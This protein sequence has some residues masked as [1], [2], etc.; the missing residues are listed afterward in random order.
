M[1]TDAIH[2][3]GGQQ[4][5]APGEHGGYGAFLKGTSTVEVEVEVDYH[6]SSCQSTNLILSGENG[7]ESLLDDTL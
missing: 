6:S 3:S 2:W 7:N 1:E 5:A 4:I